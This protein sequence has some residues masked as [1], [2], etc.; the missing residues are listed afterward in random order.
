[1][2][3]VIVPVYN[4]A[5]YISQCLSSI[6]SQEGIS[7][8]EIIIHNDAS[9][10]DSHREIERFIS[11]Y[12]GRN[13]IVYENSLTNKGLIGSYRWLFSAVSGDFVA[14]LEGD[15]YW[16]DNL[17]LNVQLQYLQENP[18]YD[19]VHT[20]SWTVLEDG[21]RLNNHNGKDLSDSNAFIHLLTKGNPISPLTVV[22]RSSLLSFIDWS[23]LISANLRTID[24]YLWLEF[25]RQGKFRFIDTVTAVYRR[26]S[27]SESNGGSITSRIDFVNSAIIIKDYFKNTDVSPL[28]NHLIYQNEFLRVRKICLEANDYQLY[29]STLDRL[30]R[31]TGVVLNYLKIPLFSF[32]IFSF[33]ERKVKPVL[34]RMVQ[35]L[36]RY[37]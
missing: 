33:N 27:S 30:E 29:R 2:I 18:E 4:Q 8:F 5:E 22:F 37:L 10:D 34:I 7:P 12:N 19:L 25:S 3:S 14:I 15:D 26:H 31:N 6:A 16:V 24:F 17:K 28:E 9:N 13:H 35:S 21:T 36:K 11:D 32:R 20:A 23:F 1:M